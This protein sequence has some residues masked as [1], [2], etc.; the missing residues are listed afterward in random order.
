[1]ISEEVNLL[2]IKMIKFPKLLKIL[3]LV[4]IYVLIRV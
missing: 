4:I 1:M 2:S 3:S